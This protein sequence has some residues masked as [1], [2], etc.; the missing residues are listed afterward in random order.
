M[1]AVPGIPE[2]EIWLRGKLFYPVGDAA[3]KRIR[4][5]LVGDEAVNGASPVFSIVCREGFFDDS[6]LFASALVGLAL[7]ALT[8]SFKRWRKRI[9]VL[10]KAIQ[11]TGADIF[12]GIP[13]VDS[14]TYLVEVLGR[15]RS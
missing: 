10:N 7:V 5:E 2:V 13:V 9:I 12:G 14:I 8:A 3:L 11:K 15:N 4:A 6:L 1:G